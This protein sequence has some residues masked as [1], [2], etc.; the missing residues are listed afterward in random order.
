MRALVAL[1][2]LA[3]T[4]PAHAQGLSAR[5]STPRPV[6]G[7]PLSVAV[8]VEDPIGAVRGVWVRM[9]K[10][11]SAEWHGAEGARDEGA[12]PWVATFPAEMVP[13]APAFIELTARV[14]G[15]RGGLL[16]EIGDDEPLLVEV[17]PEQRAAAQEKLFAAVREEERPIDLAAYVGAE[18]RAGTSARLR[19]VIGA[20][21]ILSPRSELGFGVSVGP[22]FAEPTALE[23]GG[24]MVL[25]LELALRGYAVDPGFSSFAPYA[26]VG[27]GVDLR[28]PGFD[29]FGG[30]RAGAAIHLGD[31]LSL[32]LA[33]AGAVN[34]QSRADGASYGVTPGF[35][36]GLRASIR[37]RSAGR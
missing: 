30:V 10:E 8:E 32:D 27:G 18:G 21:A 13:E 9:R 4:S 23:K 34:A 36:G 29:P 5:F 12:G 1:V 28:L 7:R 11:G 22:A 20:A 15:A 33:L 2:L 14:L 37:F 19:L 3:L 35:T 26:E 24:P 25:G 16:L 31:V 6:S 17:L